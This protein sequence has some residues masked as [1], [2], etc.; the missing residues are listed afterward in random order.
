MDEKISPLRRNFNRLRQM[1]GAPILSDFN[2]RI[3]GHKSHTSTPAADA[4]AQTEPES[5]LERFRG[6]LKDKI[7]TYV[8]QHATRETDSPRDRGLVNGLDEILRD[9]AMK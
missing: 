5:N 1:R 2:E 3:E 8:K 4:P 9:F 7:R 6:E